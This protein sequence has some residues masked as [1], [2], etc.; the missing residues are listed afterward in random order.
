[1][2]RK[3]KPEPDDREQS[4]RFEDAAREVETEEGDELFK[5]A[6]DVVVPAAAPP[7]TPKWDKAS[8]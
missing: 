6:F 3:S 1:M 7:P 4:K 2:A 8:K 5:R